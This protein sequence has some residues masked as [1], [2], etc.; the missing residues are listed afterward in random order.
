MLNLVFLLAIVAQAGVAP[1][2]RVPELPVK[3]AGSRGTL[4][5]T[6][7]AV[8]FRAAEAQKT[9][10]WPYRDL[11]QIRIE[12]PRKLVLDTFVDRSR[13]RF[14]ADRSETFDVTSG[15]IT[16]ETVAFLLAHVARPVRTSVLP[17]DLGEAST[18]VPVKHKR[19]GRGSHGT[20]GLY[21]TGLAYAAEPGTDSRFWR[22]AD[23]Q[24][25]IRTSPFELL[26][27]AFERGS[28]QAYAFDL[29]TPISQEALDTLWARVNPALSRLEGSQ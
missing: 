11:K 7:T 9:S 25:V 13:W 28:L 8:E 27:T 2:S 14:G 15:E 3:G 21:A 12:S 5:F 24:S 23:L 20:L 18:R 10:T 6:P 16:G 4:V 26:V 17:A 19:F 22:F 1:A 29:K